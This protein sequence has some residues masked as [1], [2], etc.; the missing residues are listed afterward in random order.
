MPTLLND[1]CCALC[2]EL[3]VLRELC[4]VDSTDKQLL[5]ARI[6]T[7]ARA[8]RPVAALLGE[9]LGADTTDPAR[10][11]GTSLPGAGPGRADEEIFGCPDS[12]CDR[13]ADA[14]PAGPIPRCLLTGLPMSRR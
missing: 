3:P 14:L 9:L 11:V 8:R 2:D 5:L 10:G 1:I 13:I 12:A 6:E 4:A 7:E